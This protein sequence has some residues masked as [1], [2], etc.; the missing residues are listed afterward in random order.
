MSTDDIQKLSKLLSFWTEHNQEHG[1]EFKEW[2]ERARQ[3]GK[4]SIAA[5]LMTAAGM[6]AEANKALK[7]AAKTLNN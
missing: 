1:D 5:D 2:A 7:N 6:M 4:E 3:L